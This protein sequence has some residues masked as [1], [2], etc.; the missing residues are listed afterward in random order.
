[1]RVR[2]LSGCL[3]LLAWMGTQAVCAA[4][5]LYAVNPFG[6]AGDAP[7]TFGLYALHPA[8]G[9]VMASHTITVPS[10]TIIG[11]NGLTMDPGTHVAYAIVRAQGVS[12]RLLVTLDLST[13]VGTEVGNLGDNFSSIAFRADGQLLG[14]TGDGATVPETL[15][16]IDKATATT[17]LAVP[18]GNGADGEVIAYNPLTDELHHFSGNGTAI[19]ERFPAT[20]PYTPITP[21][22]TGSREV[23]GAVWDPS[24]NRFYVTDIAS[25]LRTMAVDGTQGPLLGVMVND[26]RGLILQLDQTLAFT[27]T[28]TA[29]AGMAPVGLVAT[30]G[31]STQPVVFSTPS[32]STICTVSGSQV[33]YVGPG[34]CTLVAEQAGDASYAAAPAVSVD[35]LV[36]AAPPASVSAQPVPTL[37]TWALG[38]LAGLLGVFGLRRQRTGA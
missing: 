4:P 38:S 9:S 15:Y 7:G 31:P 37:G 13:G 14:V 29:V 21:V 18:L 33:T 30:A 11:A 34:T 12:G 26:L 8:D 20:A 32:A 19:H 3:G 23:F 28:P 5:T 2:F 1:M 25:E 24:Q 16:T 17:A 22:S 35:V 6:N 36:T 10:R 27:P